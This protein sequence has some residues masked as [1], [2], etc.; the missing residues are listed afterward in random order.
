MA[1]LAG[2]P[3]FSKIACIL[4]VGCTRLSLK[5][6][7]HLLAC[8]LRDGFYHLLNCPKFGLGGE[9]RSS[10][11]T[12]GKRH[13]MPERGGTQ[14][15]VFRPLAPC[16]NSAHPSTRNEQGGPSFLGNRSKM[17]SKAHICQC[18][19]K[20]ITLVSLTGCCSSG[21][22]VFRRNI[23][24]RSLFLVRMLCSVVCLHFRRN[25]RKIAVMSP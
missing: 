13:E 8:D 22:S 16:K 2:F 23:C 24:C 18:V 20:E 15:S 17:E 6:F 19:S 10:S 25:P 11:R 5:R 21:F 1:A 14:E 9:R 3:S 7:A 4:K 12:Y